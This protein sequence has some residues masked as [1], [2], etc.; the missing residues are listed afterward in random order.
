[1]TVCSLHGTSTSSPM[2][3][4]A[5]VFVLDQIEMAKVL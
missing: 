2:V 4:M 5:T 1:M 3:M